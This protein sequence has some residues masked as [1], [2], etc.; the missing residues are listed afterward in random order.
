MP[1]IS[2]RVGHL[3]LLVLDVGL[4]LEEE[5]VQGGRS[6]DANSLGEVAAKAEAAFEQIFLH[7]VGRGDLNSF[8]IEPL[9][10]CS[11][12]FFLPLNDGLEGGFSLWS[13]AGRGKIS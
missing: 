8:L 7:I 5:G 12:G 11:E 13:A 6:L 2:G 10:I 9:D 4:G 1:G 3:L